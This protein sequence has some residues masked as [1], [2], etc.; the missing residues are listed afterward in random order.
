VKIIHIITFLEKK[1]NDK[2]K[3][4]INKFLNKY[5]NDLE[6]ISVLDDNYITLGRKKDN[7]RV[8]LYHSKSDNLF[9]NNDRI[10]DPIV[11]MFNTDYAETQEYIKNWIFENY[12][13]KS[14]KLIGMDPLKKI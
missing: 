1:M 12:N 14:K 3:I 9:A 8:F 10:L 13:I 7:Q 6:V 2:E 5:C 4:L 11:K